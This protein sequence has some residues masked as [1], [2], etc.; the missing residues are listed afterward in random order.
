MELLKLCLTYHSLPLLF[1]RTSRLIS[2]MSTA[3]QLHKIL[4]VPPK[5][6]PHLLLLARRS[7]SYRNQFIHLQS[8]LLDW[9]LYDRDPRHERVKNFHSLFQYRGSEFSSY[10]FKLRKMTSHFDLLTQNS[11]SLIEILFS[12]Y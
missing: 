2:N 3:S 8:I 10:K 1:L 6:P 4:R 11:K 12:S 7:L 5:V 9:F